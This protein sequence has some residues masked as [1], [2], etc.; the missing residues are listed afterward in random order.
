[1]ESELPPKDRFT[2]VTGDELYRK[3]AMGDPVAIVDVRTAG[4]FERVHIPGAL[5]IPLQTLPARID[6]VPNSGVPIAVVCE[7]GIRSVSACRLLAEHGFG[8]LCRLEGGIE[9]WPGPTTGGLEGNGFHPHGLAP[10]SFLVD[11]FH[12]LPRGLALDVAMGEGRNA[13]YLA[14]R[15]FDVDG[16]DAD[17]RKVAR[18]RTA[19]RRLGAPIRALLGNVEDGTHI[20]PLDTYDLIIVFNYLHRPLFQDIR[21]GIVPGG[22]VV[23]QTYTVDQ[24]GLGRPTNPDYLLKSGE[25]KAVFRDW[26]VLKFRELVGPA[27]LGGPDRAIASIIARKPA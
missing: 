7:Q 1:V 22:V 18:A 2:S 12:L 27:R 5:L 16:V 6:E 19:S 24:A 8:P 21:Q 25:L 9:H 4:E 11:H 26:E 17:P 20:I 23:Y 10:S 15:G 14:T 13:I 3:L